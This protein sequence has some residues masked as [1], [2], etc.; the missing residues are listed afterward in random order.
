MEDI[1]LII[2]EAAD[3]MKK[4]LQHLDRE[5]LKIR[6]G[7]ANPSMLEG[8]MV[9][10]Y[11]SM[12]PLSQISNVSTPDARTLSVQP[13][14]KGLIPEI[15]K[16]IMNANLG[17][18][19]Q[20]NGEMVIIAIPPLTEDRR[21][22][23]VKRAKAEGEDAKVSIRSARKDANDMLKDLDGVSEDLVKDAEERVQGLT[24]KNVASVDSAIEVKEKEIMTV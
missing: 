2:D 7:R 15:E 10:Y 12:S 9:E 18:N 1:D 19:P 24:N 3:S 16:A 11:G 21:R 8:V 23:L 6:A 20:N 22:E 13:W 5:L 4:S 17:F 14:E